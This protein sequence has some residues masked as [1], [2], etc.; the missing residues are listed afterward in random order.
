MRL[1]KILFVL[2]SSIFGSTVYSEVSFGK[3]IKPYIQDYCI[4]CHGEEKQKGDRRY[5]HLPTDFKDERTA[6]M[7]QDILDQ[8]LLGE[9]P[10]KKPFPESATN[11][12]VISWIQGKF[13]QLSEERSVSK[14]GTVMRRLSHMEYTNSLKSLFNLELP[15]FDLTRGLTDDNVVHGFDTEAKQLKTTPYLFSKYLEIADRFV[16]KTYPTK[17]PK[18]KWQEFSGWNIAPNRDAL[19]IWHGKQATIDFFGWEANASRVYLRKFTSPEDGNYS[20]TI[21]AE[22]LRRGQHAKEYYGWHSKRAKEAWR[23]RVIASNPEAGPLRNPNASDYDITT[24]IIDDERKDHKFKAFLRK[25]YSLVVYWENGPGGQPLW[26]RSQDTFKEIDLF[27]SYA[28]IGK[29]NTFKKYYHGPI[30]R[31]HSIKVN[32]P[33]FDS[34]PLPAVKSVYGSQPPEKPSLEAAQRVIHRFASKAWRRPVSKTELTPIFNLVKKSI[35]TE[36]YTAIGKG[37]KAVLCSPGF[38]YHN[39]NKGKLNNFALAARLSYFLNG[40][41]PDRQL[42]NLASKKKL[43]DPE[44]YQAQVNRLLKDPK[45][46]NFIQ[47]FSYQWL[48]LEKAVEMPPDEKAFRNYYRHNIGQHMVEETQQFLKLLVDQNMSI[49]N[50]LDSNFVMINQPLAEYYKIKGVKGDKFRKVAVGKNSQRGGLIGQ[51]SVLTATSNGVDTS[52]IVRGVWVMEKLMGSHPPPPPADVEPLEPDIRGSKTIKERLIAHREKESCNDCHRKFDYLGLSLEKFDPTG[53][54]RSHY[55][56]R[57]KVKVDSVATAPNGSQISDAVDLKTYLLER[58]HL[59]AKGL[60]E[61]LMAYA[62]GRKMSYLERAE[63][64]RIVKELDSQNG[65]TDLLRLIVNSEVFKNK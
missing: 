3:D 37:L 48:Q 61:N 57:R 23:L 20:I 6:I 36:G 34:W 26:L 64:D 60:T 33:F 5:D 45:L 29:E 7:W 49:Y 8:L 1:T 10:P 21:N 62:T 38:L 12:K 58:K 42:L 4:R 19:K 63:I 32:G 53:Q 11:K 59:F 31:M 18:K 25:G 50:C 41:S 2:V 30:L 27:K 65:F 22:A 16:E 13:K 39:Q 9:M 24:L 56:K 54:L 44:I 55:D 51:A 47:N 35:E 43:N 28:K 40:N 15:N 14:N 17:Q 46:E 52:P